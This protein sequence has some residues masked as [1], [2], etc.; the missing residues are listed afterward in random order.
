MLTLPDMSQSTRSVFVTSLII[1]VGSL[2]TWCLWVLAGFPYALAGTALG[3]VAAV[4][5]QIQP[6]SVYTRWNKLARGLARLIITYTIYLSF[7]VVV[8]AAILK[9]KSLRLRKPR[10]SESLWMKRSTLS[11]AAYKTQHHSTTSGSWPGNWLSAYLQWIWESGEIWAF[12]LLPF[13]IL[14]IWLEPE[15]KE[16]LPSNIYTLY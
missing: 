2:A 15:T 14:L 7:L 9:D 5:E 10:S 11:A 4:P 8:A 3:I 1:M 12:C 13:F 16:S 6:G